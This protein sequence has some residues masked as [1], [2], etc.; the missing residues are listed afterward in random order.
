MFAADDIY[1]H[2]LRHSLPLPLFHGLAF[3]L[4]TQGFHSS[5]LHSTFRCPKADG[6]P[7]CLKPL[8]S[9]YTEKEKQVKPSMK[10]FHSAG[11]R[12][13]NCSLIFYKSNL[14]IFFER[15]LTNSHKK[16]HFHTILGY[17]FHYD[18][19]ILNSNLILHSSEEGSLITKCGNELVNVGYVKWKPNFNECT[20]ALQ[21][22]TTT[23][24]Y[25]HKG[26][27]N[28]IPSDNSWSSSVLQEETRL[29]SSLPKTN[30]W[31]ITCNT[32]ISLIKAKCLIES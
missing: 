21:Y 22:I 25:H 2:S 28:K 31:L 19:A 12:D 32:K 7:C 3:F 16:N 6:F 24:L 11:W 9:S 17:P 23:P 20:D 27:F 14:P 30:K 8:P 26:K 5:Q 1:W 18:L 13:T 4:T 10:K 15:A 29:P